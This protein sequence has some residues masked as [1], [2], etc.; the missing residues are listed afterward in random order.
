MRIIPAQLGNSVTVYGEDIVYREYLDGEYEALLIIQ[1][2]E[3]GTKWASNLAVIREQR[4]VVGR[5]YCPIF[6]YFPVDGPYEHDVDLVLIADTIVTHTRWG[7]ELLRDIIPNETFERLNVIPHGTN[8]DVFHP[9]TET[10]RKEA[11]KDIF[12]VDDEDTF[13]VVSVNRNSARKDLFQVMQTMASLK[14]RKRVPRPFLYVHTAA[15]DN[16]INLEAQTRCL[17]LRTK[18]DVLL[19][20]PGRLKWSDEELSRVYAAADCMLI[21]ARRESWGLS[22]TEAMAA[23]CPVVAPDYGPFRQHLGDDRGFLHAPSGFIW[24]ALDNRGPG[25]LT[26]PEAAANQIEKL[27]VKGFDPEPARRYVESATWS[28]VGEMWADLLENNT[29]GK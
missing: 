6:Y 1:D 14:R 10:E 7:R 22:V 24:T 17:G 9:L 4:S 18:R 25:W 16:G 28:A 2:L 27:H 26:D 5:P 8:V 11:R 21:T 3:V 13:V 12:F 19:A 29:H 15:I 20:S 23:G